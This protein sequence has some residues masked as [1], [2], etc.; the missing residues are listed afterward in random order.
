MPAP[1]ITR[2]RMP[3]RL[4]LRLTRRG[5]ANLQQLAAAAEAPVAV[6]ARTLLLEAIEGALRD[7]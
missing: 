4:T 3:H 6:I 7:N 5:L 2:P 1:T